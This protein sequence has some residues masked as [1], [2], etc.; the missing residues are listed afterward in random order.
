L[1][2]NILS[3][4]KQKNNKAAISFVGWGSSKSIMHDVIKVAAAEGISVNYLHYE[5]LWPLKTDAFETFIKTN[6]N[7]HLIEGNYTGQLGQLLQAHA[8]YESKKLFV[9]RL[10]KWD[11]RPFFVEEVMEYIQKNVSK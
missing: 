9:G 8:E 4:K 1:D 11:G 2:T 6:Q 7:L 5:Y 10:L 3:E